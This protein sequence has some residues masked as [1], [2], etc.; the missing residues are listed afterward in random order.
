M[1]ILQFMTR[2]SITLMVVAVMASCSVPA[3][4]TLATLERVSATATSVNYIASATALPTPVTAELETVTADLGSNELAMDTFAEKE[5]TVTGIL[6][7]GPVAKPDAEISGMTWYGDT[8]ILLP[9]HPDRFGGNLFALRKADILAYI[10]GTAPQPLTP[11]TI[12][13]VSTA[14]K[15]LPG[16]EGLE[17]IAIVDDQVFVTIEARAGG[18]MLGYVAAGTIAPD[19]SEIRLADAAPT[20]IMPQA[21]IVNFSDETI[22]ADGDGVLTIYESNGANVNPE[23]V[24]HLFDTSLQPAGTLSFPNVEYRITDATALDEHRRFWTINYLFPGELSK[25]DPAD[26]QLIMKYGLGDSHAKSD[27]VERLVEFELGENGITLTEAAPLQL[28]LLDI[29]IARNWEGIARLD[30]RDGF[31]LSTDKFPTTLLVFVQ[32]P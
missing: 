21:P 22:V 3:A 11:V 20:Q 4:D 16:Y 5:L 13:F 27:I 23:P 24:A 30:E 12:P 2:S 19:L 25:L 26:D 1:W 10:D 6:L 15:Q 29:D 9:Q 7:E 17:A 31:L 32:A 8:L 28:Q 18:S 14:L